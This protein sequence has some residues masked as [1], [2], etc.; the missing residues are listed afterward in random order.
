VCVIVTHVVRYSFDA[1]REC[2]KIDSVVPKTCVVRL[3]YDFARL[4][5]DC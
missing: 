2:G 4:A 3:S 1:S 5:T